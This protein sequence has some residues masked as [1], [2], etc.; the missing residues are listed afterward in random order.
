MGLVRSMLKEKFLHL[1]LCKDTMNTCSYVLNLSSRKGVKGGTP[2]E[3]LNGRKP[4][5]EHIKMFGYVVC[6]KTIG[7][8]I[9]LED[10]SRSMVFLGYEIGS[11]AYRC[12]DP[13]T[14]KFHLSRDLI[15]DESKSYKFDE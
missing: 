2:Y 3:K 5:V 9:K 12:L 6:V 7:K 11:K 15:F 10:R 13:I 14:F 1:E 4:N 8:L